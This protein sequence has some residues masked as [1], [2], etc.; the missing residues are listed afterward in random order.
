MTTLQ[1][2]TQA[3]RTAIAN[4][5]ARTLGVA[6]GLSALLAGLAVLAAQTTALEASAQT[7]PVASAVVQAT[8]L[9][10]DPSVPAAVSDNN[11]LPDEPVA[12]F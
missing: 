2:A 3:A 8:T 6:A 1:I 10:G 4:P 9:S 7:A 11:V 5:A 12:T